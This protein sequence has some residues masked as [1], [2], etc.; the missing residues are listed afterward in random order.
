MFAVITIQKQKGILRKGGSCLI[1]II[2][3]AVTPY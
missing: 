1:E 2:A 3:L